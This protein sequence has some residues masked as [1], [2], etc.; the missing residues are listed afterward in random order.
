MESSLQHAYSCANDKPQRLI[1]K[2]DNEKHVSIRTQITKKRY[3]AAFGPGSQF[4]RNKKLHQD[5]A[6]KFKCEAIER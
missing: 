2:V 1:L 3:E 4:E 5:L 6:E